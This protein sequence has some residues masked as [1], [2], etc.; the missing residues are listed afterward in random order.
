MRKRALVIGAGFAGISAASFM[1]K[2]GWEVIVLE[3]HSTPGGRAR[4]L[5]EAGF[6]FDMGPSWYWMHDVFERYFGQFGK[7]SEDYYSV[8]RLD[9]SYRVYWDNGFTNIPANLSDLKTLF[10][11]LEPGAAGK[12]DEF[13]K[14]AEYKYRVGIQKLVYKPGLSRVLRI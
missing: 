5:E 7:R 11:Q 3:K 6:R 10:E 4:Q 9:P 12:L 14:E 1:A 2:A 8:I 13:L